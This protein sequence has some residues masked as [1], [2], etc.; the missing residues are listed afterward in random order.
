VV[1]LD[2]SPDRMRSAAA[3]AAARPERGGLPNVLFIQAAVERLPPELTGVTGVRVLMPWGSLL[4]AALGPDPVIMSR[5]AQACRPGADLLVAVNLHAWRPRV[6]EVGDLPE[7]D[8]R[9]A[10]TDLASRY[11]RTGWRL[12]RAA[13]L[14]D[15]EVGALGTSWARRL[16]SSR[17]RLDVLALRGSRAEGPSP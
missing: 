17:Q 9:W 14:T 11:A 16:R 4:R 12:E 6:R 8:P 1:G 3:R 2:A 10:M 15:A 13:Y 5:L 7:P